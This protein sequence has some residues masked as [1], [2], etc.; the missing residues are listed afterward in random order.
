M[1]RLEVTSE[2]EEGRLSSAESD[3]VEL[4]RWI[5]RAV[6]SN[7]AYGCGAEELRSVSQDNRSP[8]GTRIG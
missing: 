6:E 1:Q 7:A 8:I 3:T 5:L 2:L 4:Q